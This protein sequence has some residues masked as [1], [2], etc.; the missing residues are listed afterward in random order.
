MIPCSQ[1]AAQ[2]HSDQR[3]HRCYHARRNIHRHHPR[4]VVYAA[5]RMHGAST[6]RRAHHQRGD[7]GQHPTFPQISDRQS[8]P[9]CE[10]THLGRAKGLDPRYR[11]AREPT[12]VPAIES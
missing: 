3:G 8:A 11:P 7:D 12:T 1:P 4:L 6:G 5:S 10:L 2:H 9:L